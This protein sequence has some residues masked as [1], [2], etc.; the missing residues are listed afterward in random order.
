MPRPHRTPQPLSALSDRD[1]ETVRLIARGLT[2]QQIAK[3]YGVPHNTFRARLYHLQ[4]QLRDEGVV[5]EDCGSVMMRVGMVIWAHQT[6]LMDDA[7]QA[8]EPRPANAVPAPALPVSRALPAPA[9]PAP[10]ALPNPH[11]VPDSLIAT[12]L[13]ICEAIVDNKPRGDLRRIATKVLRAAGRRRPVPQH[14]RPALR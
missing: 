13:E 3:H 1:K 8:P 11:T 12:V 5:D 4:K 9:R 2:N 10:A 14:T 6:G 7:A